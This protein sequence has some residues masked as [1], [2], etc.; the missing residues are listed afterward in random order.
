VPDLRTWQTPFEQPRPQPRNPA[1]FEPA[2]N[3]V[4]SPAHA[5][6]EAPVTIV[7]GDTN[8]TLRMVADA[9]RLGLATDSEPPVE[10]TIPSSGGAVPDFVLVPRVASQPTILGQSKPGGFDAGAFNRGGPVSAPRPS[11]APSPADGLEAILNPDPTVE[12]EI[13]ESAFKEETNERGVAGGRPVPT[14]LADAPENQTA[15]A[16]T[17]RR[18][19]LE[20]PNDIREAARNLSEAFKIQTNE[21]RGLKPNEPGQLAQYEN[22]VSFFELMAAGLAD[23]ADALDRALN[24][25]TTSSPSPEPVLLGKAA[26][27]ARWLQLRLQQWLEETGTAVIDVPVRIGVLCAG[28]AFLHSI[29]ADSFGAVGTLGWL[30]RPRETKLKPT[31]PSRKTKKKGTS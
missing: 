12:R 16:E 29:G 9:A 21:L 27:T 28:V 3:F 22:L 2:S 5:D 7:Q 30:V 15:A 1:V 19:L 8:P 18:K 20:R 26:E 24:S 6:P 23:L 10:I 25:A 14:G 17:M 13:F 4:P 31:K 11:A